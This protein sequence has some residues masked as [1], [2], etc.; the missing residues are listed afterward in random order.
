MV[1]SSGN[2]F[3]AD[4]GNQFI[5]KVV[6]VAAGAPSADLAIA[7]SP[8]LVLPPVST[9]LTYTL[10]VTNNGPDSASTVSVTDTLPG[11]VTERLP[12]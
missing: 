11:A 4:T 6:A 8:D 9:N 2:L 1:D 3:I 7:K 5:R 10:T 12:A